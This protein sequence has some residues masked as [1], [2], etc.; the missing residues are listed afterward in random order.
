MK[1]N[2]IYVVKNTVNELLYVGRTTLPLSIRMHAHRQ[3]AVHKPQVSRLYAAMREIGVP[4]FYIEAIETDLTPAEGKQTERDYIL[5]WQTYKPQKGYNTLIG[6]TSA[7][8]LDIPVVEI[9][10][11]YKTGKHSVR[12]I[13][14]MFGRS[15]KVVSEV[16][17]ANGI[18]VGN[19]MPLPAKEIIQLYRQGETMKLIGKKYGVDKSA[20]S[21]VLRE[22]GED[23]R[24]WNRVQTNPKLTEAVLRELYCE[25]NMTA[26]EIGK[27]FS[28]TD[29]AILNWLKKYD[30][31][32]RKAVPRPPG[33][34]GQPSD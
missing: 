29:V 30:I 28:L 5:E 11:L 23:I 15:P 26:K 27:V 20:I 4:N 18:Y 1:L 31:P 12:S 6:Q 9:I 32:R 8:W 19:S 7:M 34:A 22:N 3:A 10:A 24:V 17:K 25:K 33:M 14:K 21:R 13:G 2:T 16:L